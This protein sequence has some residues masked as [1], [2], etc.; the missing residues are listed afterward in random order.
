MDFLDLHVLVGGQGG[1]A[2]GRP[3]GRR[4]VAGDRF[5]FAGVSIALDFVAIAFASGT[6]HRESTRRDEFA[7]VLAMAVEGDAVA[8]GLGDFEQVSAD[9]GQANGLRGRS[10]GIGDRHLPGSEIENAEGQRDKNQ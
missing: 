1:V 6:G 3:R 7:D 8:L 2:D 4:R 10:A 5:K 9:T